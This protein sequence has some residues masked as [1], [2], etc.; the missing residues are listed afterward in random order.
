MLWLYGRPALQCSRKNGPI[1]LRHLAEFELD[2]LLGHA[3]ALFGHASETEDGKLEAALHAMRGTRDGVIYV[4]LSNFFQGMLNSDCEQIEQ[5]GQS[6]D[7][8]NQEDVAYQKIRIEETTLSFLKKAEA[9][10]FP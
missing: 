1:H 3:I 10:I 9:G 2:K 7:D 4:R 5:L 6:K 8:M